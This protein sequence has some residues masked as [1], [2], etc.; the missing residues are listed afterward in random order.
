[1]GPTGATGPMPTPPVNWSSGGSTV[2]ATTSATPSYRAAIVARATAATGSARAVDAQAES[3]IAIYAVSKKQIGVYGRADGTNKEGV[4]GYGTGQW[5]T[6]VKGWTTSS[7]GRGV[8]GIAANTSSTT[9]LWAAGVCGETQSTYSFGVYGSNTATGGKAIFGNSIGT[10]GIGVEGYAPGTGS[11]TNYGVRGY[12]AGRAWNDATGAAC[13]GYFRANGQNARGVFGGVFGERTAP[14]SNLSGVHG[15]VN[16]TNGYGVFS[17]GNLGATGIKPFIQP[18]PT[19]PARNIQFICLEGNESGTYFRGTAKLAAGRTEIPIPKEWKLV[20]E[21][22]GITVQVTPVGSLTAR[23]AVMTKSRERIVVEGTEDCEFDYF[24]NGVRRGFA[25]YEPFIPNSAYRPEIKGVPFG[26][27]YPKALRDI[28]VQA[29]VL[30]ADYTPNEATAARLDWKL[31]EKHEVP[32]EERWWLPHEE[33][34]RL[35]NARMSRPTESMNPPAEAS[36][37]EGR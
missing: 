11:L 20:T 16:S 24:V 37:I 4:Y 21:A 13:G 32:V 25:E 8:Y 29:G 27:Q 17:S 6:G 31:K 9:S 7:Q 34:M 5:G 28:L 19:D 3:G 10:G 33:R 12:A 35:I 22:D 1:M 36:G 18:H 15:Y 14:S 2:T 30:N 26:T 23:L